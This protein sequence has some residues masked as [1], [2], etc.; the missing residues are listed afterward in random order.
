MTRWIPIKGRFVYFSLFTVMIFGLYFSQF[1]G[2][3]LMTKLAYQLTLFS[4]TL[5]LPIMVYH[6]LLILLMLLVVFIM[7]YYLGFERLKQTSTGTLILDGWGRQLF[8]PT[9]HERIIY[10]LTHLSET[11]NHVFYDGKHVRVSINMLGQLHQLGIIALPVLIEKKP[12]KHPWIHFERQ[13]PVMLLYGLL[14]S[15]YAFLLYQTSDLFFVFPLTLF[16]LALIQINQLNL[17]KTQVMFVGDG[18]VLDHVWNQY[19][20]YLAFR[21]DDWEMEA[22][23]YVT[24]IKSET[25][26]IRLRLTTYKQG[27]LKNTMMHYGRVYT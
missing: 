5:Y 17:S 2:S 14:L 24:T 13:M 22:K 19:A 25:I 9:D 7:V 15:F 21:H 11:M 18:L 3:I 27:L 10:R 20:V 4:F 12:T 16:F 26:F 23:R 1:D 6:L 8:I